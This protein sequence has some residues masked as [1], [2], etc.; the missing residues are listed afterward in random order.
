MSRCVQTFDGYCMLELEDVSYCGKEYHLD[1]MIRENMH[2][3]NFVL[4]K[5]N[6]MWSYKMLSVQSVV[7]V[8]PQIKIECIIKGQCHVINVKLRQRPSNAYDLCLIAAYYLM[9]PSWGLCCKNQ[10]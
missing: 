2:E 4:F 8:M 9:Y 1:N 5:F 3:N 7:H 10:R 6:S